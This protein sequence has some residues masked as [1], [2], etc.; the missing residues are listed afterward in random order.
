MIFKACQQWETG[1]DNSMETT[2][3]VSTVID[4]TFA[5]KRL[6]VFLAGWLD[7]SSRAFAQRLIKEGRIKVNDTFPRQSYLLREGDRLEVEIPPPDES[8]VIPQNL[9]L[10][11]VYQDEDILVVNK[12]RGMVVHPAPGHREGTMVNALLYHCRDLSGIGGTLRP[13]IVHRLDKDTS[14][15]LVVAKH[16][17]SHREL[18]RQLKEKQ[19]HREY[20]ALVWGNPTQSKFKINAPLTRNPG[21]RKK[22]AVVSH[23]KEAVTR[24][25]V[26]ARF[27]KTSLIRAYLETGRTHQVRVHLSYSGFPLVGDPLYGGMRKELD[28][29]SWTGQALHARRLV[30]L[31]PRTFRVMSFVAP[32]PPEFHELLG[33]FR[34][35]YFSDHRKK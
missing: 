23:G 16:D 12:P 32:L 13:G 29:L 1:I 18:S 3:I 6:D 15:L 30:L 20:L 31:H 8:E 22:M 17:V 2:R 14:G 11:F 25:R 35:G 26:L 28:G 10:S 4:K 24:F 27:S 34:Q 19:M 9:P 21:N 5:G 7:D 33:M